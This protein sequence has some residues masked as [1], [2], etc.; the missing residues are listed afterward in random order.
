ME[1]HS[2][3]KAKGGGILPLVL[4]VV[5]ITVLLVVAKAFIG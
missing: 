1:K 5:I 3:I 2:E 4:Y